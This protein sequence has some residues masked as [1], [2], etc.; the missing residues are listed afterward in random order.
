MTLLRPRV[1]RIP[2]NAAAVL[3]VLVCLFPVYWMISTAFKPSRDIQSAD[4]KLFPHTWTL[5]HFRT[6]VQADG[7]ELF[8][9]NSILVTLTSILLALL[10]AIGSAYAVA[11]MRWKGRMG[12]SCSWSSSPRWRPGSR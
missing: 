7:F 3:T 5:D 6:A 8:W 9:R 12:S 4:P 2:L 11:R 10:V 1:R